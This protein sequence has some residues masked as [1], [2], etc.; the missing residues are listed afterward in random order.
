MAPEEEASRWTVKF[1][2]SAL[3]FMW[4][5]TFVDRFPFVCDF[6]RCDWSKSLFV[7]FRVIWLVMISNDVVS[8]NRFRVL[9]DW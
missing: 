1:V 2:K 5:C 3:V 7:F 8:R 4:F 9:F 6:K